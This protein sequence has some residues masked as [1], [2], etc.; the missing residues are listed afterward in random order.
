MRGVRLKVLS[1]QSWLGLSSDRPP[2]KRQPGAHPESPH[3]NKRCSYYSGNYK[4]FRSSLSGTGFKAQKITGTG[5]RDQYIYLSYYFTRLIVIFFL[6]SIH[7]PPHPPH[8]SYFPT[9]L[10]VLAEILEF[11]REIGIDP[12]KEPELMWLAREG[13]V[14]PLPVEWKP[15]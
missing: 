9:L 7:R 13:I 10:P 6:L 15:W 12:I 2:A 3:W 4:G 11:A 1:L 14:A 8:L 5:G